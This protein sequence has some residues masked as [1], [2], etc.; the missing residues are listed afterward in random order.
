VISRKDAIVIASRVLAAYFFAWSLDNVSY[1]PTDLLSIFH[2]AGTGSVVI[3]SGF[4]LKYYST[5]IILRALRIMLLTAAGWFF[6]K[7]DS[8]IQTFLLPEKDAESSPTITA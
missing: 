3:G 7:C 4:P 1:L 5:L 8:D 6:Y 2:S